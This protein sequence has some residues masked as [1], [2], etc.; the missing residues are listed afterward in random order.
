MGGLTGQA[1]AA[2]DVRNKERQKTADLRIEDDSH[3]RG[4]LEDSKQYL[5]GLILLSTKTTADQ[6]RLVAFSA[7]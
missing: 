6:G 1:V 2:S 4:A 3:C 5:G 7:N